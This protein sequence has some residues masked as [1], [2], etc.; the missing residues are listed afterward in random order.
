MHRLGECPR[1][2]ISG[3]EAKSTAP[4]GRNI[5]PLGWVCYI[6]GMKTSEYKSL[7]SLLDAFS[8]E[9]T[10]VEHLAKLRWPVASRTGASG[11]HAPGVVP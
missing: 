6:S 1:A 7:V 8:D 4:S 9:K 2:Y 10:C 3:K 11:S 5:G